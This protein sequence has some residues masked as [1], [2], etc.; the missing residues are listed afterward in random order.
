MDLHGKLI[1]L[2]PKAKGTLLEPTEWELVEGENM[3]R[4]KPTRCI[5]E[6]VC[7]D[8][9]LRREVATVFDFSAR[10]IHVCDGQRIPTP[11]EQ[12]PLGRAAIVILL[13]EIGAWKPVVIDIPDRRPCRH[14]RLRRVGAKGTRRPA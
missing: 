8:E 14:A 4:H 7:D 5:F 11:A 12:V 3:M 9:A 1:R 2:D 10:L 6:I 13:K